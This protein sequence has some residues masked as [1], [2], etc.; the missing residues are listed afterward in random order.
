MLRLSAPMPPSVS[1]AMLQLLGNLD[2]DLKGHGD[3]VG[4]YA[5]RIGEALGLA[6]GL[7]VQLE[8]GARL[9]DIGKLFVPAFLVHKGAAFNAEEYRIMQRHAG[10]GA[11]FLAKYRETEILAAV[12]GHHHDRWDGR[13]YP[14]H[15]AGREIPFLA[16]ITAVA[17]AYDAMTSDRAGGNRSHVAAMDEI[18]RCSGAH[19]CPEAVEAFRLAES[20][21]WIRMAC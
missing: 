9:H 6:G 4:T 15:A 19:F 5:R 11:A 16:R 12:A 1:L 17:D 8:L 20:R 14:F 18:L 10:L 13:G 7:V 2:P 3:R 21:S